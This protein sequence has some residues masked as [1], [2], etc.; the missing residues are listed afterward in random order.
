MGK[1]SGLGLAIVHEVVEEHDGCVVISSEPNKGTT[2]VIRLLVPA[3]DE[4]SL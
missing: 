4:V 2:F 1:G 3:P